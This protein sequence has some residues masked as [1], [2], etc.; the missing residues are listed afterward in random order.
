MWPLSVQPYVA[1]S[2]EKL[3]ARENALRVGRAPHSLLGC[4]TAK[5]QYLQA[6]GSY[7]YLIN[8]LQHSRGTDL[9]PTYSKRDC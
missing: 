7:S 1:V 8:V 9:L 2:T 3:A 4:D 6:T 5:D